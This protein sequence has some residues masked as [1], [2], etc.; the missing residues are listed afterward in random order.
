MVKNCFHK[1]PFEW[2]LRDSNFTNDKGKVFSC[3]AGGGGSSMGYKLAGFDVIGM[4]EIDPD[5]VEPYVK[6]LNPKYVFNQPLQEL[7]LRN[8]LPDEL[9]NLDILDG[10]P[11]C[12]S[13]SVAGAKDKYWGVKRKFREG[14]IEQVLDTLFFDFID[15]AELL[16]PKVVIAENVKGLL[17]KPA[18]HY[19]DR[20][21]RE[22]DQAGYYVQHYLLNS[23]YMGVPQSRERAFFIA[24]RKDLAAPYL[25]RKDLFTYLPKLELIFNEKLI[26]F[27]EVKSGY[28]SQERF[29]E[30]DFEVWKNRKEGDLDFAHTLERLNGKR[31]N[32][33]TNYVYDDKVCRTVAS[34]SGA[35]LIYFSEPRRL[36][37]LE[38][39]KI[40]TFPTDY[41]FLGANVK[42]LIGMS[43]PPVMIAQIAAKIYEQWNEIFWGKNISHVDG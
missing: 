43:V 2:T 7:K 20:I 6:N 10:S 5:M 33:N 15:F 1:F 37:D 9:Y 3:F 12:S 13:F 27:K 21:Y 24:L 36:N 28:H 41:S 30:F 8:D 25:Y 42:Y 11:P 35:K 4:N 18:R 26:P 17:N 38:L 23:K 32:W 40:G 19:V 16:K 29:T 34:F 22:F 39:I 31:S 14:Q